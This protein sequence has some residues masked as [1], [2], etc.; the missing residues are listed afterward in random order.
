MTLLRTRGFEPGDST[1]EGLP[2]RGALPRPAPP[3]LPGPARH[4]RS[5]HLASHVCRRVVG[6]GGQARVVWAGGESRFLTTLGRLRYTFR[7]PR[8]ALPHTLVTAHWLN[9]CSSLFPPTPSCSAHEDR[10]IAC[11]YTRL[12]LPDSRASPVAATALTNYQER[13][14]QLLE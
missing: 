11:R 14:R 10:E 9:A 8:R 2:P 5:L 4:I 6:N 3:A 7:S 1:V 13:I 12:P